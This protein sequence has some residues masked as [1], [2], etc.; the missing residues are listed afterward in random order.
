MSTQQEA[1]LGLQSYQQVL[2][3]S[4]TVNSGPELE[5]VQRV[6][7]R[8]AAATGAAGKDFDWQVSLVQSN[9]VNAFCLPGGKIVVYT[10][11]LPFA[12]SEAALA[13]VFSVRGAQ[14]ASLSHSAAVPNAVYFEYAFLADFAAGC[15]E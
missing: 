2:A 8:L 13:T 1:V 9:Q 12:N 6:V 10:G 7:K 4:Q 14:A 3:Q 5:M 11:I 15:R